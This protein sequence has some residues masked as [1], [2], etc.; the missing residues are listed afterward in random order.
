MER[1]AS[2]SVGR[3]CLT[4]TRRQESAA[5]PVSHSRMRQSRRAWRGGRAGADVR[6]SSTRSI[7]PQR[8]RIA[9]GPCSRPLWQRIRAVVGRDFQA[10]GWSGCS[11]FFLNQ[12]EEIARR[13]RR[14]SPSFYSPKISEIVRDNIPATRRH[15]QFENKVVIWIGQRG[16]PEKEDFLQVTDR[17]QKVEKALGLSRNALK[18]VFCAN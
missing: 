2:R 6:Q 3:V 5:H 11:C 7:S 9:V 13:H 18:Q 14:H 4:T 10:S 1:A 16:P 12:F 8:R 17:K 15:R